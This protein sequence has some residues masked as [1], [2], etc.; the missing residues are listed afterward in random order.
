MILSNFCVK[1][2]SDLAILNTTRMDLIFSEYLRL[3]VI[4]D[5]EI[6]SKLL[7]STLATMYH[8]SCYLVITPS[9]VFGL[10]ISW[11]KN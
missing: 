4:S 10:R 5:N 3:D 2:Q 1:F 9:A 6:V 11:S 8:V 7:L